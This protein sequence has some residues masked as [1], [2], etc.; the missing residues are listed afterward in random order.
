LVE[1]LVIVSMLYAIV[2]YSMQPDE[3]SAD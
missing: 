3:V 2:R 1:I